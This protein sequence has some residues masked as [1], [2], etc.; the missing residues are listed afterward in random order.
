MHFSKV[1]TEHSQTTT[2]ERKV[3]PKIHSS[4]ELKNALLISLPSFCLPTHS[5]KE[6]SGERG[7]IEV[8][9][10]F[11]SRSLVSVSPLSWGNAVI[12]RFL[13]N[14][15]CIDASDYVTIH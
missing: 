1:V 10:C 15:L 4:H 7:V 5:S 3:L 14:L 11:M 9:A 6:T 2:A 13:C 12:V 8:N